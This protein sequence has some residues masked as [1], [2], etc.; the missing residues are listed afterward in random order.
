MTVAQPRFEA[1]VP[2]GA[3][4]RGGLALIL[5]GMVGLLGTAAMAGDA[6]PPPPTVGADGLVPP[7]PLPDS[8]SLDDVLSLPLG[9]QYA[10]VGARSRYDR[11]V[12][13]QQLTRSANRPQISVD[14]RLRYVEPGDLAVEND[15]HDDHRAG[16]SLRQKL[17]DFGR[18]HSREA[19]AEA[20]LQGE[21]LALLA[22]EKR[23]RL[24]LLQAYFDVLL[25]D[26]RYQALNE[27]VAILFIRYDRARDRREL[28]QTSDYDIAVFERDYQAVMLE[29]ARADADRRLSR[30]HLAEVAGRPEQLPRHL[31]A[32]RLDALFER[33]VPAVGELIKTAL[34]EDLVLQALR[35]Q[36]QGSESALAAARS[37]NL[38][39]VH[40]EV[41]A[42]Y[43]SREG[44][45]RDPFRAG[46]YLEFPLFRGGARNA[47]IGAAQADRMA[48][49]AEMAERE[50][51]IRRY[52]TELVEMIRLQQST[53]QQRLLALENYAELNFMRNQT[54]Y[55][56]EKAADLGDAMAE[57]SMARLER[58]QTTYA[59]AMRWAELA[60]L[61]NRSLGA[62]LRGESQAGAE[63]A[64][65]ETS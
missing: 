14:G 43:Y 51:N 37:G 41:N 5:T 25:A 36:R 1:K 42:D 4:C 23:Q 59:L 46:V 47:E 10:V 40:G 18:Q 3:W 33:E 53:A 38:P 35:R 32:P 11:R 63:N 19:A 29:R 31:E 2:G 45:T 13:E 48:A 34:S 54:L 60:L 16:L 55:Q 6:L 9:G 65:E 8:L 57:M 64:R 20:R 58:M 62:V 50:A 56:M 52:A 26:Q 61:T 21:R 27:R 15:Q 24:E 49:V 39:S 7:D 12:A 44:A 17:F 22:E 28:G 30:R